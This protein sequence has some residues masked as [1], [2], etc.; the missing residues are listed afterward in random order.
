MDDRCGA[1]GRLSL[2]VCR[3]AAHP[4]SETVYH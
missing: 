3:L 4:F 1:F 2:A